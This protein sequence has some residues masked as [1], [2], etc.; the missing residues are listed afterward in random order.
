MTSFF[1]SAQEAFGADDFAQ[2]VSLYE[3][4]I[5]QRPSPVRQQPGGACWP[6]FGARRGVGHV[7]FDQRRSVSL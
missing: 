7:G 2:A 4:A 1:K 5:E 3:Q 6:L